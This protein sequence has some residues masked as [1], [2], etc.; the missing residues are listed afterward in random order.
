MTRERRLWAAIGLN[1]VIVAVQVVGGVLSGSLGLLADAGHNVADAAAVVVS[2]VA[3]RLTRRPATPQR[4]FGWH[5]ST[6]LAAQANAVAILVVTALIVVEAAGR[7][8]APAP[9]DGGL[10]VIV[11]GLGLVANAIAAV[12]LH[13]DHGHDLN[14][15]SA[16]LHTMGDAAASAGV[17]AAGAVIL[18]TGGSYWLDPFVS[19]VIAVVI[20]WRGV[21]LL[22]ETASVLLE[23]TPAGLDPEDLAVAMAEVDGVESV[24]DLHVWSLSSELHALAA[25]LVLEGHPTLEEAQRV[26]DRVRRNL[27]TFAITHATLELE[28]EACAEPEED[29]CAMEAHAVAT[30]GRTRA[31]GDRAGH[32][33][34]AP[35]PA[36][37]SAAPGPAGGR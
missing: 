25:H 35:A 4:S 2:L 33:H 15:R 3:V 1:V 7:L 34:S 17:L 6:I 18:A 31:H 20:G 9:V 14:M 29:P 19:L 10:V 32:D 8:G 11:A 30:L 21:K 22:G 12:V 5:R 13:R 16:L 28:C 23:S 24:H 27:V 26:G 36:A 37:G